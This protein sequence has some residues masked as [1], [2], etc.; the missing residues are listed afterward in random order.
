MVEQLL[1]GL[2][3]LVAVWLVIYSA[4][5]VAVKHALR[6]VHGREAVADATDST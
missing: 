5:H 3:G 6:D 4:V 1:V 2:I